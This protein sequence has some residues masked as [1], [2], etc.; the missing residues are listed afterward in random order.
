[1]KIVLTTATVCIPL[2]MGGD[3]TRKRYQKAPCGC[4]FRPPG[5]GI[6]FRPAQWFPCQKHN[7]GAGG[8]GKAE[9]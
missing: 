9:S 3:G 2:S 1:M 5:Y 8:P 6:E 4:L 7:L